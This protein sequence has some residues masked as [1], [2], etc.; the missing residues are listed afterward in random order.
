MSKEKASPEKRSASIVQADEIF[1]SAKRVGLTLRRGVPKCRQSWTDIEAKRRNEKTKPKKRSSLP[2]APK[3]FGADAFCGFRP[4][5]ADSGRDRTGGET[6]RLQITAAKCRSSENRF[7]RIRLREP[8]FC[9]KSGSR[10]FLVP[11]RREFDAFCLRR[12]REPGSR[13]SR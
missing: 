3:F 1:A 6:R 7:R 11:N 10:S 9:R 13:P 4:A 2:K 5:A 8:E 12:T